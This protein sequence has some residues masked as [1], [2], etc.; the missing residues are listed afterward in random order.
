MAG[1]EQ[2]GCTYVTLIENCEE[3]IPYRRLDVNKKI[4]KRYAD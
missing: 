2:L 1:M 4:L 3:K